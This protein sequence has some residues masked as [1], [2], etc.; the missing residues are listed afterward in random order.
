MLGLRNSYSG[1]SFLVATT[2]LILLLN[3]C[4]L[5]DKRTVAHGRLIRIDKFESQY[6]SSRNVEV[7]LPDNY[8]NDGAYA[9]LY[10][11]DGHAL[12][13]GKKTWNHQEWGVDEN[14]QS[15]INN[16]KIRPVIVI[17]IWNSGRDR[18]SEYLPQKPYENLNEKTRDSLLNKARISES[19]DLFTID[20]R[21][22][23]YLK[24][25]TKE[26][27]PYI[28][29]NFKTFKGKKN[30]YIAG[31]SFG[32]LISLYAVCE[33]P[34]I[35]GG[36]ACLS[37]HWTGTLTN[38]HAPIPSAMESYLNSNLPDPSDCILYFDHGTLGLDSLYAPHQ[39]R[40]DSVLIKKGYNDSNWMTKVFKGADHMEKD[41]NQRLDIPLTFLLKPEFE[42]DSVND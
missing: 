2:I 30:T 40:I 22:D 38:L 28:D 19:S 8:P 1:L 18:Q 24:F 11:H 17:G 42:Q 6:V 33:Y 20:I 25:I 29:Q 21:S 12:F 32:G 23:Q 10:M 3:S 26:L 5:T 9:T 15:L 16:Q 7:W 4:D 31:S 37:T 14:V 13:D 34:D 39:K 41:W 35:F 36:A 27:K